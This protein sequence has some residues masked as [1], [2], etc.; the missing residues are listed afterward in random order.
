MPTQFLRLLASCLLAAGILLPTE[1][2]QKKKEEAA[3]TPPAV[4]V[5]A[6]QATARRVVETF[7]QVGTL[8]ASQEVTLRSEIEGQ[9]VKLLFEE[10]KPVRQ[11]QVLVQLDTAKI[12][13]EI[14]A[15]EARVEQLRI[16]LDNKRKTV[17]RNRSL[18][19]RDMISRQQFDNV[20]TEMQEIEAE[21]NQVR[22]NVTLQKVRLGDKTIRA[23][24]EGVAGVRKI[25]VGDYL[26]VADPV[27]AVVDLDPL[28][29]SFQVPER[30]KPRLFLEQA[31]ILTVDPY[32]GKTFQ[33]TLSFIAPQ[34][35]VVT[36]T[37]QVK[38]QVPNNEPL[39]N[40]G[41]FA[42]VEVVT[43]VRE[44][45]LTVPWEAVIQTEQ[46]TYVYALTPDGTA[47]KVQVRLGKT[48]PQW[49]E[50]VEGDLSPG[51]SV[52]LEGKFAVKDGAKVR[53]TDVQQS[54]GKDAG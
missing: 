15:L 12:E 21:I 47:R 13:A 34:V 36:R 25:S 52:V 51:T 28:E 54:P 20:T 2:C 30:L 44:G 4:V 5:T 39:L 33:G 11:G 35:D 38:A 48:T 7:E 43:D 53:A 3:T 19:E 41:M 50:L 6:A 17:E 46:G 9:V 29:I 49:A 16:R 45:A 42:R 31:C 1:G 14:R 26:R 24:F 32:P 40:P 27:V 22:A 23:P 8:Q 37:F 18:A 10:G